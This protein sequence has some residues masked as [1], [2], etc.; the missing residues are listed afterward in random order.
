MYRGEDAAEKFVCDLQLEAKQLFDEFIA[1]PK[2][3]AAYCYRIIIVCQIP[4]SVIYVQ[5]NLEMIKCKIIVTLQDTIVV[6][7]TRSVIWCIGYPKLVGSY[8]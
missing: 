7:L 2:P 1:A 4:L 5:N 3:N 6:L 8:L